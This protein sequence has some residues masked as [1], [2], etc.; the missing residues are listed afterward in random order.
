MHDRDC[1]HR[2]M[3]ER[4]PIR[5]HLVHLD[6]AW[7][8]LIEHRDYPDADSRC[9]GRGGG[10]LAAVGGDHQIRGRAVA[11]NA[12]RRPGASAAGAMHRR[13]GRARAGALPGAR[14]PARVPQRGSRDLIG[15]GNLTVT[16]ETDD[17]A[18]RYQGIV[19]IAGQRLA[20]SL[21]VYFENSEQLPTRL[22][23][24][25]DSHGASACCCRNFPARS[26][27]AGGRRRCR[28]HRRCV[29][30]RAADR[31][32]AHPGGVA[33]A[34]RCG[35]SAPAVQ[36]RRC[37]AVRTGAGV[38]SMPL[39]ARAGRQHA[40]E[41]GRGGKPLGAGRTRARSKC[42]AISA[43]APMCSTPWTSRNCSTPASRATAAARCTSPC[44]SNGR[45]YCRHSPRP[46]AKRGSHWPSRRCCSRRCSRG[47]PLGPGCCRG[48]MHS[49]PSWTPFCFSAI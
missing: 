13:L 8:A 47:F 17:G 42:I 5:G 22:W 7:R 33:H 46:G 31:R 24:H 35:N 14:A 10:G 20:E 43:I 15:A 30:A 25:A 44:R 40:A 41:P 19:P 11:A 1:L 27:R 16:L 26:R 32:D 39:L 34:G 49:S 45:F 38:F 23:L 36:R 21:Q 2:F 3:F 37:A 6:A 9:L 29:A 4:Y 48:R 28:G 12:G 18:Q